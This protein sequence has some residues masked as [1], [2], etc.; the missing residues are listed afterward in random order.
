MIN[1][2]SG[3][4]YKIRK[5]KTFYVCL[6]SVVIL[7]G[8]LYFTLFMVDE[9]RNQQPAEGGTG[10]YVYSAGEELGEGPYIQQ[11]G[12]M[13][14]LQQMLN[15]HFT[16]FIMA[17]FAS[18]FVI[19]EYTDGAVKNI[20]GKGYSRASVFLSKLLITELAAMVILGVTFVFCVLAGGLLMGKEG[21]SS[22]NRGETA[23][24]M[25]MQMIISMSVTGIAVLVGELTRNLAAGISISAGIIIFSTSLAAGAD[26]LLSRL[27][28]QPSRYWPLSLQMECPVSGMEQEF[29][30]RGIGASL[31]W[32]F[33]AVFLGILHFQKADVT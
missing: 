19:K 26:T 33:L 22:M 29:V 16:T 10:I 24:Y 5:E 18:I 12:I 28:I 31:T 25:G 30:M 4:W 2:L 20:V 17:V 21:F 7:V 6:M 27:N 15:G 32:L 23:A 13:G 9:I 8:L 11:V 3:E 1:I 14:V